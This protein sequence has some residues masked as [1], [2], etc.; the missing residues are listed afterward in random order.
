MRLGEPRVRANVA[1]AA[2]VAV[3]A[4][5]VAAAIVAA[6]T[7][8][9]T[10]TALFV[11]LASLAWGVL[12]VTAGALTPRRA[13][14]LGFLGALVAGLAL[15][16]APPVL[17]DDL[18]RYLWDGRVTL[19]GVNPY[20][21]AP[22]A[23]A[24]VPLHDALWRR[25]NHP[26]IPTI[27]PPFAQLLFAVCDAVAHAPVAIQALMLAAHLA[28][29]PLV[30]ALAPE[31]WRP[32]ATLAFALCPLALAESALAG[33]VDAVVGLLLAAGV[34]AL[35]RARSR[36]AAGLLALA[37]ATKIVGLV[38]A[39][40]VAL[41]SRR[42]ALLAVALGAAALLPLAG[43][44]GDSPGGL[45][46][47]SR[48]WRGNEGAFAVVERAAEVGVDVVAGW[49]NSSPTHLRL[50]AL[51]GVLERVRGTPLDPRAALLGAK[52]SVPDPTDFQRAYVAGLI[53]RFVVVALV[54]ALGV[55]LVR[56]QVAPLDAARA[57]VLAVLLFAP[58]LHPWYL[59]WL[60]PLECAAGGVAGLVY[61]VVVL[62]AYAP[63]D[64][65]LVERVWAEAPGARVVIH[66]AVW[67]V[68]AV[69]LAVRSRPRAPT[70]SDA[71]TGPNVPTRADI[72]PPA[73]T[74]APAH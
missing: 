46:H 65:W 43:A 13:L 60:L 4:L 26:E 67:A 27:Y 41:R 31:A 9:P 37:T 12:L 55:W 70:R 38:L 69:E 45:G 35:V 72:S 17:S 56:R 8:S 51:R 48:R 39:P 74:P 28:T 19:A 14:G 68:L 21:Y 49:T 73:P 2:V 30:A 5:L 32:R 6:H 40:L 53:A 50:P 18:Y 47:Y 7:G 22:D 25:I 57:V 29:V 64:R 44:G 11:A 36:V 66:G 10:T 16:C 42:D 15:L 61:A 3:V 33:H 1:H 71:P 52:K 34:L 20:R 23:A 63:A 59:L 58:Q 54:L 24:L 62:A